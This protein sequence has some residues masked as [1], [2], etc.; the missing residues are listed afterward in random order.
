M[1]RCDGF[2]FCYFF[3]FTS[4]ICIYFCVISFPWVWVE[5]WS[6]CFHAV[7]LSIPRKWDIWILKSCSA[8]LLFTPPIYVSENRERRCYFT[9]FPKKEYI[10]RER[11]Y[12]KRLLT[13]P[14]MMSFLYK[15][16]FKDTFIIPVCSR[17]HSYRGKKKKG[18]KKNSYVL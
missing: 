5:H 15:F 16:N 8:S 6:K 14:Y 7:C 12:F 17:I 18:R 2:P 9:I 4:G 10:E 1:F 3:D 13:M 11:K